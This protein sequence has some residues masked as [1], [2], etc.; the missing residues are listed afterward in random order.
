MEPVGFIVRDRDGGVAHTGLSHVWPMRPEPTSDLNV[1]VLDFSGG[2]DRLVELQRQQPWG[3]PYAPIEGWD[4]GSNGRILN[5]LVVIAV[6][7]LLSGVSG[8]ADA[9]AT[10]MD[11]LL[12]RNGLSQSYITGYGADYSCHQRTRQFGHDLDPALPPPPRGALAGGR[13][14]GPLQTSLTILDFWAFHLSAA[15]SM[16]PPPRSPTTSVSVGMHLLFG[17]PPT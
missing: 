7:H 11:Y 14:P 16:S 3:Q 15:T 4:W 17:S 8:Y 6:A 5:N 1:H 2:A 13:T 10:G 12:G 9:V